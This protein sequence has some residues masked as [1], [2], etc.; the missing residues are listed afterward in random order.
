MN[1]KITCKECKYSKKYDAEE[2]VILCQNNEVMGS[3]IIL[4]YCEDFFL[5]EDFGCIFAKLPEE[6]KG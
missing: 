6:M 4:V 3:R 1:E 5:S 2:G